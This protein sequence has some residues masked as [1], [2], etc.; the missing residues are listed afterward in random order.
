PSFRIALVITCLTALALPRAHAS[1]CP[2]NGGTLCNVPGDVSQV[3]ATSFLLNFTNP[4]GPDQW[5]SIMAVA[6]ADDRN[7]STAGSDLYWSVYAS[8]LD[9]TSAPGRVVVAAPGAQTSPVIL[10]TGWRN[11]TYPYLYLVDNFGI[12]VAWEDHRGADADIY[13]RRFDRDSRSI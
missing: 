11:F 7:A 6:W 12:I 13:A 5:S 3:T 10:Q 1:T 9:S 8:S 4:S 2:R